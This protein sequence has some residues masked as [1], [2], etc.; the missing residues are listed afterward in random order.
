M[1]FL[2]NKNFIIRNYKQEET[3]TIL[4]QKTTFFHLQLQLNTF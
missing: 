4:K 1:A 2:V 3:I